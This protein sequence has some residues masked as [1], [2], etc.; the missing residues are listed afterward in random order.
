AQEQPIAN[1]SVRGA[2]QSDDGSFFGGKK[3]E[4]PW[5]CTTNAQGICNADLRILAKPN[6]DRANVCK[7]LAATEITEV[8]AAAVK[9]SYFAF[10]ADG[11]AESYNLLQKGTS[12]KHGD[13]L[14]KS[15]ENKGA[16]DALVGRNSSDFYKRHITLKDDPAAAVLTLDTADA[17]TPESREYPNTEFLRVSIDRK[18]LQPSVEVVATDTYID[19]SMHLLNAARYSSPTGEKN[20][21]A[22]VEKQGST[23]NMRDLFERKCTY[24]EIASFPVDMDTF[25]Q[26]AAAYNPAERTLWRFQVLAKSGHERMRSLSHAEFHG[27][28]QALDDALAARRK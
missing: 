21:P 23:C 17:H 13:Y 25:R 11:Q 5:S 10:F 9:T 7:A 18:T 16:L 22:V 26:A 27:L 14:F 20:T 24:Q 2:C 12:W 3:L 1:A 15:L 28:A 4:A 8:G 6:S 19:F